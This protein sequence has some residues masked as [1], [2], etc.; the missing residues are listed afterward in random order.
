MKEFE[1]ERIYWAVEQ[2]ERVAGDI[3]DLH[4]D[5]NLFYIKAD[6]D[7]EI[8][9]LKYKRCLDKIKWCDERITRYQLQQAVQGILWQSEIKFYRRLKDKFIEIA[10]QF[11]EF[12]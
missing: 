12:K 1:S 7:K 5:E 6:A 2:A 4:L 11:E 8:R 9:Y 10:K 3:D